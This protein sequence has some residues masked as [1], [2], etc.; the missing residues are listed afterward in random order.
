MNYEKDIE[1]EAIDFLLNHDDD[2]K[3]AIMDRKDFHRNDIES[4][5]AAYSYSS[6]VWF[7]AEKMYKELGDLYSAAQEEYVEQ[8]MEDHLE[9]DEDDICEG[10]N[11]EEIMNIVWKEYFEQFEP[12]SGGDISRK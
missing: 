6:D 7:K 2:F 3:E 5:R 10:R 4:L 1:Q 11:D 12:E 8:R 9:L